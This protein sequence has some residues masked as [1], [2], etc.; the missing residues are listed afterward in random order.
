MQALPSL[1]VH[2]L[3]EREAQIRVALA[4]NSILAVEERSCELDSSQRVFV[5]CVGI[6][7]VLPTSFYFTR[8]V[9]VM[10]P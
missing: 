10:L 9:K 7:V 3:P 1:W 4:S 8:T 5:R 6:A 2:D